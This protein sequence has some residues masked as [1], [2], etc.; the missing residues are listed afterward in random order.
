M[1]G[2]AGCNAWK[3]IAGNTDGS[4][5]TVTDFTLGTPASGGDV[6]DLSDLLVGVPAWDEN[7]DLEV[8]GPTT[9]CNNIVKQLQDVGNLKVG[10]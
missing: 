9:D 4:T 1:T 8:N 7:E 5:Y 2:G 10:L 3:W 6:L